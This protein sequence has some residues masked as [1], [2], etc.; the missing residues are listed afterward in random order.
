MVVDQVILATGVDAARAFIDD[1]TVGGTCADWQ[2][3]WENTLRVL[4]KFA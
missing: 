3:L 2:A 4:Q 1:V